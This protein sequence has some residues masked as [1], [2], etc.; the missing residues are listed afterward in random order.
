MLEAVLYGW[1]I[2]PTQLIIEPHYQDTTLSTHC[3]DC[4]LVLEMSSKPLIRIGYESQRTNDKVVWITADSEEE[5][6]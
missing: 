4:Q 6:C 5:C 1:Y 2:T 3:I